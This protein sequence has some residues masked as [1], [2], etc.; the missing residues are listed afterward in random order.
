MKLAKKFY[1]RSD[2]VEVAKDLLGKFLVTQIDGLYTAGKIVETEAYEGVIDKAS[3]AYNHKFSRR[4]KTLYESGGIAYIYLCYGIHHL[5]NVVTNNEQIPH[6]VLVRAVEPIDGIDI[7]LQRRNKPI[8]N[9][10]LASGPG[11]LSQALGISV[12][13]DQTDLSSD[14]IWIEDRNERIDHIIASPRVGVDYAQDH[15]LWPYRFR[16]KNSPW[17]GRGK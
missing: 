4:T 11:T 16:I 6:A 3:H 13:L 9:Y 15:A 10:T 17:A 2:V 5:F 7:M 12:Q 14:L 8:L 1:L